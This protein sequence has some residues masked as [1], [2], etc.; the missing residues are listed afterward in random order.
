MMSSFCLF[1]SF[2]VSEKQKVQT[3][4]THAIKR[5][6]SR[7]RYCLPLC[8]F[9][10]TDQTTLAFTPLVGQRPP[11]CYQPVPYEAIKPTS[12]FPGRTDL[13]TISAVTDWLVD[14]WAP[15]HFCL[16][17]AV[18]GTEGGSA[19]VLRCGVRLRRDQGILPQDRGGVL[20]LRPDRNQ[21]DSEPHGAGR[22]V[23]DLSRMSSLLCHCWSSSRP[24]QPE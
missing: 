17:N 11:C 20:E 1:L 7:P 14:L 10:E 23:S 13:T 24:Q 9:H 6:R 2:R 4:D 8:N 21:R 12:G 3:F 5:T 18:A 16:D 22:W 19:A 15:R